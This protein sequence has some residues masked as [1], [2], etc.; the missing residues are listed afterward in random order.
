LALAPALLMTGVY[1]AY[2]AAMEACEFRRDDGRVVLSTQ[3]KLFRGVA[4]LI[5]PI[6][7]RDA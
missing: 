7:P 5:G 6:A 2:L 3:V 1:E 4:C